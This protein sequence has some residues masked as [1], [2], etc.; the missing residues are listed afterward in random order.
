MSP[1]PSF[2]FA[3]VLTDFGYYVPTKM[4]YE[5]L[6][7]Q[8]VTGRW[9]ETKQEIMASM[10]ENIPSGVTMSMVPETSVGFRK[11]DSLKVPEC[12]EAQLQRMKNE[13]ELQ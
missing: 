11:I 2:E 7:G 5:K 13:S 1:E 6:T 9:A 4:T 10:K 3:A 8:K 12:S